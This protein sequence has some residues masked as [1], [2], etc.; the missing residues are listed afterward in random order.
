LL[1]AKLLPQSA[2]FSRISFSLILE[3]ISLHSNTASTWL[4]EPGSR[5]GQGMAPP[6][7]KSTK[8]NTVV[9]NI[10]KL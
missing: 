6:T 2:V 7:V 9:R 1:Q 8:R 10:W 5:R 3:G 4:R